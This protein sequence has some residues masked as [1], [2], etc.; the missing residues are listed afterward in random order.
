MPSN[1]LTSSESAARRVLDPGQRRVLLG[2]CIV[3]GAATTVPA[4]YNYVLI[5]MLHGLRASETQGSLLRQLPS[6]GGL[7]VIFLAGILGRRWGERRFTFRCGVLF[8][9][10]N[11]AVAIAPG[12][13]VAVAGL[14]LESVGASGLV[15]VTLAL[16]SAQVSND[17]ARASAFAIFA[18]A[19]PVIYVTMPLL[20]GVIV[21]DSSWRLVA[22]VWALSGIVIL[23]AAHTFLPASQPPG[24]S[25]E[26]LTSALAGV[27]LTA[28]VQTVSFAGRDG[29]P[30][31]AA[32]VR[33]GITLGALLVLYWVYRRTE[34]PSLSL[35]AL[36][37]GGMSLLLIT[38]ILLSF[39]N[40]WFYMT[41]GLQ[42]I[43]GLDVLQTAAAMLPAQLAGICGAMIARKALPRLGIT[44]TGI[45]SLA[46]LA[47]SLLLS[48]LITASTPIWVPMLVL[49]FYAT[50]SVAAS[51]PLTNAIM[52]LAPEGEEGS[53]SALR[54]ASRNIGAAVGVVVMSTIVFASFSASLTNTLRSEG[55]NSKQSV[56]IA[57]RIRDGVTSEEL[58]ADYA[59]PLEQ[60]TRIAS[61]QRE[62]MADGLRAHGLS[63]CAFTALCLVVYCWSRRRQGPGE[64]TGQTRSPRGD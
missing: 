3:L 46:A 25:R 31:V 32:L 64:A 16:L 17:R 20:A 59:V 28:A 15:V 7:L 13:G 60:V 24:D 51:V 61:A 1:P 12:M 56:A 40:L 49:S 11:S 47:L 19:A 54:S 43:Y 34:N 53:A 55:L 29:L 45:I 5:P 44:L 48:A 9:L 37:K 30:S 62:A 26:L 63:G 41:V 10:G 57:Q 21:D 38:I 52:N 39:A 22:V 27:V 42:Y 14:V 35:A 18:M 50:A 36:R 58:A 6:I 4:S 23:L 8:T 33:L 2:V